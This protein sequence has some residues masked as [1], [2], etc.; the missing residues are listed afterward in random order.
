MHHCRVDG[1]ANDFTP[2]FSSS[3]L[4]FFGCKNAKLVM[5]GIYMGGNVNEIKIF[6]ETFSLLILIL[7]H[8]VCLRNKILRL[9]YC[10]FS[11]VSQSL[12]SLRMFHLVATGIACM[13]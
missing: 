13:S 11:Y 8:L 1:I 10:K 7:R 12:F 9:K 4:S 5:L 3:E 6:L 2:Q